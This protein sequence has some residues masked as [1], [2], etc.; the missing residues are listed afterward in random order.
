M[1][2]RNR[3]RNLVGVA[4]AALTVLSAG[5][6]LAQSGAGLGTWKLNVAKSKYEPGPSPTSDT[7]VNE[8]WATDGYK[9]IST[10]VLA[11]GTLEIH[12]FS[13]HYDGKDYKV[14]GNPAADTIALTRLDPMTTEYTL[15]KDAK[16]VETG[17]IVISSDGK[18]RTITSTGVN[19]K[20]QKF[21]NL[22]VF[23]KQ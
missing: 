20:G 17:R 12:E 4:A 8:P 18:T 5:W 21:S 19:A 22:A 7:R 14:L 6:A 13:A 1:E 23:D 16:V 15:K 11:N 3:L 9:Q 2:T 10:V